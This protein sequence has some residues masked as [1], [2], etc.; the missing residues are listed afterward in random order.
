LLRYTA[1]VNGFD[2]LMITKL[3]VLDL[4]EEIPVCVGYRLKGADVSEMPATYRALEA[5]EPVYETLPGW[6]TSTR[7]LAR[8]E[9]LPERAR[10]YLQFLEDRTGVE[11]GGI[12]T[13]PERNE[14]IIRSGSKLE[15]L[16][17]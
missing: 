10:T 2:T 5:I 1:M 13:G 15:R 4:L 17:G 16:I 3:D 8:Y 14:T 6:R 12:S 11:I 9:D 7:G